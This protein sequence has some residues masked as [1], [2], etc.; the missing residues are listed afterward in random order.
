[1]F[2]KILKKFRDNSVDIKKE[3]LRCSFYVKYAIFRNINIVV[4]SPYLIKLNT[5]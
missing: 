1:M 2:N 3:K 5:A 4:K